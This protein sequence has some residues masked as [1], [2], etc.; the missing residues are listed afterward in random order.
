MSYADSSSGISNSS[1]DDVVSAMEE[2]PNVFDNPLFAYTFFSVTFVMAF[3]LIICNILF[4]FRRE[5]TPIRQRSPFI[6]SLGTACATLYILL[7][8]CSKL[9]PN[10]PCWM[11]QFHL[12]GPTQVVLSLYTWRAI[13]LVFSFAL[14]K[15]RL[16]DANAAQFLALNNAMNHNHSTKGERRRHQLETTSHALA[17]NARAAA[18]TAS[19]AAVS[20]NWWVRHRHWQGSRRLIICFIILYIVFFALILMVAIQAAPLL[21]CATSPMG[22]ILVGSMVAL[23]AIVLIVCAYQLRQTDSDCFGIKRYIILSISV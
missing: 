5:L 16:A 1:D 19:H 4:L 3:V 13:D 22:N 10:Y 15:Y 2:V 6:T 20:Q 21:N 8:S 7:E 12:G 9:I 11:R 14:T 18:I 17:S 23:Y